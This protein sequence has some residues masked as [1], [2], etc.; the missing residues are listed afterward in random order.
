MPGRWRYQRLAVS[1]PAVV[2]V[3][4]LSAAVLA[5]RPTV[6]PGSSG[7]LGIHKIKHIVVIMQENR[8]F[9][10]YFGTFPGADGIPANVCVP[11]P[12]NGG[13]AR[14]WVDH[15]DGN[16]N[17]PHAESAFKADVAGGKM[18]GFVSFAEK[19][20]CKDKPPCHPDVMGYHVQSDIPNYWTY[21]RD[22]VLQ[23]HFFEA[24]GS[25]SLPAHLYE[26]SGW[27]ANCRS[28]NNPMS[29]T[30]S[31]APPD[32]RPG[33]PSP[34]AWT[35]VTWLLHR[36]HVSWGYYLDHGARTVSVNHG[37]WVVWNVLP[38]F[39]DVRKDG[40]LSNIRSLGAF[41]QQARTGTLPKVSWIA[42][43]AADSE[44]PGAL[45]STGQ[46][47]TTKIINAVMRSP[48]WKSTAIFLNWDDWGGFYDNV[49]PPHI[50]NLGYGIR[51]PGIVISP[52]AK[53]GYVDHQTL[54]TDAYLKF[55]EDD[56]LGGARLNPRTDGRPDSR[57]DVRETAKGL[58]NL[59]NDFNF[60]QSPRPPII[61][62]PCP[63]TT[64]V[65]APPANCHGVINLHAG[66][67]GNS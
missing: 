49:R 35:D 28:P 53:S 44:H 33:H 39:T 9:D 12:V 29:C 34:F 18:N 61:L 57:P 26:V 50:D 15:H 10:S 65:P 31:L 23:D 17:D 42:P 47:Y 14:P 32:R 60:S 5:H 38:G 2:V 51:V 58:G 8:S 52:Y 66:A 16:G 30:S 13:C 36:H 64:L 67:W 24:P 4:A 1:L 41:F 3:V 63:Q 7:A 25:W 6:H 43:D 22:F 46:A 62:P 20:L 27:S 37:V 56:F 19:Y 45:V 21:A 55:I 48:D 54:T 59:I 11:D 40:Q